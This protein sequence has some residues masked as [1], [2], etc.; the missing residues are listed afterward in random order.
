[1]IHQRLPSHFRVAYTMALYEL[2]KG[3]SFEQADAKLDVALRAMN[4]AGNINLHSLY[5]TLYTKRTRTAL[6]AIGV[7]IQLN[8]V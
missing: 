8:F 7:E 6:K 5:P 2:V 1:M 4:F 3:S